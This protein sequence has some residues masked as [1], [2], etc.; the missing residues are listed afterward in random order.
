MTPGDFGRVQEHLELRVATEHV[1]TVAEAG[2]AAGPDQTEARGANRRAFRRFPC[3][4]IPKRVTEPVDCA[5]EAR[6]RGVVP[7]RLADLGDQVDE[8]LLDDERIRP[9]VILER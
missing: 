7:K 9:E 4:R 2:A 1:L 8:V 3:R 6:M 5:D